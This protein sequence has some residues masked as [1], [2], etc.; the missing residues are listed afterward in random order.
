M[1]CD[2]FV[3]THANSSKPPWILPENWQRIYGPTR[4]KL[5]ADWLQLKASLPPAPSKAGGSASASGPAAPAFTAGVIPSV[6]VYADI[7]AMPTTPQ[8]AHEHRQL[9]ADVEMPFS[10]LVAR[11]VNKSEIRKCPAAQEAL[12]K[13]WAK[14]RAAGCWNEDGVRER[15]LLKKRAR[16]EPRLT[17]V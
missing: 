3:K 16:P 6:D 15:P 14:L 10:A 8:C 9:I 5:A 4:K 12:S 2:R 1:V 17:L 11:P 7:P 13:E